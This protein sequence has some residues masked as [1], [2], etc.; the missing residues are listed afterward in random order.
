MDYNYRHLFQKL[1]LSQANEEFPHPKC[2]ICLKDTTKN[3]VAHTCWPHFF[4]R[5]VTTHP[6]VVINRRRQ[7]DSL[8]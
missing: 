4:T 3:I 7:K 2:G 1:R 5:H 8:F 6:L